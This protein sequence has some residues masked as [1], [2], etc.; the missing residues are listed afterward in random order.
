VGIERLHD[1]DAPAMSEHGADNPVGDQ[2]AVGLPAVAPETRDRATYRAEYRATV[3]AEYRAAHESWDAASFELRRTWEA[4][5]A[6]W[7]ATER[8]GQPLRPDTLSAPGAW[9]GDGGRCLDPEANAEVDRSCDRIREVGENVIVPGMRGIEAEDP[10]RHL[11]GLEYHLKGPERLKEKVSEELEAR[12]GLTAAQALAS[13]PDAV[14]FTFCYGEKHYT[15]GVYADLGRLVA[16]GFE[17]AKPLRN[18]WDSDQYKGINTQWREPETGQRF[19]VQFHTRASYEAKQLSH[20][21]Y[22]RI[23]N[24]QTSDA[25]LDEL[26]DFQREVCAKIP[27]PPGATE[28]DYTQRKGRNG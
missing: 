12:P 3:D 19:E 7:P 26:E 28:I 18:S 21:A 9:R 23:R 1:H 15:A 6:R 20:A 14:R 2:P 27:I 4:H 10:D 11:I 8:S 24:P 22:E 17:L 16:R 25:E 5:E 13:V